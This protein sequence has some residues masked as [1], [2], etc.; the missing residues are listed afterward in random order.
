MV[1]KKIE[2]EGLGICNLA[3]MNLCLLATWIKRYKM[4]GHKFWKQIIDHKYKTDA[5]NIKLMPQ[6]SLLALT[7]PSPPL[8]RL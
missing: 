5:P 6:I 2:Y 4:D 3:E 7:K 1:A 8:G